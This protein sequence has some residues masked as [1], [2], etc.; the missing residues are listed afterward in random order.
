[1]TPTRPAA[2]TAAVLADPSRRVRLALE[3]YFRGD[4][5]EAARSFEKL[6]AE[7]PNNGWIWAFLGAAQYSQ[8]AFEA[9]PQYRD[10]AI[11]AFKKARKHGR[12]K[13]GLPSKYF[14]RRIRKA[15]DET[16]G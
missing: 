12:F 10:A 14:S 13:N 4:F 2:A 7:L 6:T 15:Y 11:A 5:D 3:S 16:A 1:V 8:Y 9:E